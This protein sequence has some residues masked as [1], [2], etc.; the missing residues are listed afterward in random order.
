MY[1]VSSHQV[2]PSL[3]IEA[4]VQKPPFVEVSEDV[5][6]RRTEFAL[7]DLLCL[8]PKVLEDMASRLFDAH[9]I[10]LNDVLAKVPQTNGQKLDRQETLKLFLDICLT[11]ASLLL[12]R[13]IGQR[14]APSS[15]NKVNDDSTETAIKYNIIGVALFSGTDPFSKVIKGM[16]QSKT[17]HVG[18]ILA[19]SENENE[20]YCFESTGSAGEV[21]NGEAPHV[22]ITPWNQVVE[23]YDGK[24]SYRLTVFEDKE[25]T[26][27]DCVTGFVQEYDQKPYTKNPIRLLKALLRANKEPKVSSLETVFCSELAAKMFMD[28]EILEKGMAAGNYIPKDFSTQGVVTLKSGIS[29]TPAFIAK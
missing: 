5:S 2:Q 23:T 7:N 21:L 14:S 13:M 17:S 11:L 6:L 25:R 18:V 16:T 20:W 10:L 1:S 15:E 12:S 24:V 28:L 8:V 22:R 26:D 9:D 19:N 4:G 27:S 29:L 3:K